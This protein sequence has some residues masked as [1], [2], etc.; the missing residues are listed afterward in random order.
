[1]ASAKVASI[2]KGVLSAYVVDADEL[3]DRSVSLGFTTT[4]VLK[5]AQLK[6]SLLVDFGLGMDLEDGSVETIDVKIEIGRSGI[7]ATVLIEGIAAT[8][9]ACDP[10]E[11]VL[12]QFESDEKRTKRAAAAAKRLRNALTK[13]DAKIAQRIQAWTPP[14]AKTDADVDAAETWT[15]WMTGGLTRRVALDVTIRGVSLKV[16]ERR[17]QAST[18]TVLLRE[19][20]A[21]LER[22]RSERIVLA[23]R[24]L[25]I[26]GPEAEGDAAAAHISGAASPR[27]LPYILRPLE[28]DAET[29]GISG[30]INAGSSAEHG[31]VVS[32]S[33]VAPGLN[34]ALTPVQMV[35][36]LNVVDE[37]GEFGKFAE[38]RR[39]HPKARALARAHAQTRD[40]IAAGNA[41]AATAAAAEVSGDVPPEEWWRY[42]FDAL[43]AEV[44]DAHKASAVVRWSTLHKLAKYQELF[45]KKYLALHVHGKAVT[46]YDEPLAEVEHMLLRVEPKTALVHIKRLRT[47]ALRRLEIDMRQKEA[48]KKADTKAN[49]GASWVWGASEEAKAELA[50]AIVRIGTEYDAERRALMMQPHAAESRDWWNTSKPEDLSMT[51]RLGSAAAGDSGGGNAR[52]AVSLS[53]EL[54]QDTQPSDTGEAAPPLLRLNVDDLDVCVE[55]RTDFMDVFASI[56]A[57]RLVEPNVASGATS[58]L[59]ACRAAPGVTQAGISVFYGGLPYYA[60][61]DDGV[62]GPGVPWSCTRCLRE[63]RNPVVIAELDADAASLLGDRNRSAVLAAGIAPIALA[64]SAA[65]LHTVRKVMKWVEVAFRRPHAAATAEKDSLEKPRLTSAE[66]ALVAAAYLNSQLQLSVRFEHIVLHV[67]VPNARA[68]ASRREAIVGATMSAQ[69][70][71]VKSIAHEGK[72]ETERE[73]MYTGLAY[74]FADIDLA[75]WNCS[76]PAS[77]FTAMIMEGIARNPFVR[78][79][80][81]RVTQERLVITVSQETADALA[82]QHGLASLPQSKLCIGAAE[83]TTMVPLSI[84]AVAQ[85]GSFSASVQAQITEVFAPIA[86][87]VDDVM[88]AAASAA[89]A[90]AV[91][92]SAVAGAAE[93]LCEQIARG[94]YA[95]LERLAESDPKNRLQSEMSVTLDRVELAVTERIHNLRSSFTERGIQGNVGETVETSVAGACSAIFTITNSG[96]GTYLFS[97][98]TAGSNYEEGD[99]VVVTGTSLNG[100]TPANDATLTVVGGTSAAS[101][102]AYNVE[103]SGTPSSPLPI[104]TLSLEQLNVCTMSYPLK[105]GLEVDFKLGLLASPANAG[106]GTDAAAAAEDGG[107][108]EVLRIYHP[109]AKGNAFSMSKETIQFGDKS[110]A[111]ARADSFLA[112]T[113]G[114]VKIIAD[115][116]PAE[117]STPPCL[118]RIQRYVKDALA[119]FSPPKAL[120]LSK[121]SPTIADVQSEMTLDVAANEFGDG[122]RSMSGMNVHVDYFE[123]KLS[124]STKLDHICGVLRNVDFDM[125]STRLVDLKSVRCASF[126]VTSTD[127]RGTT[128]DVITRQPSALQRGVLNVLECNFDTFSKARGTSAYVDPRCGRC[129]QR[130]VLTTSCLKLE[131]HAIFLKQIKTW[132]DTNSLTNSKDEEREDE[133]GDE[134]AAAL[135]PN[136]KADAPFAMFV[137]ITLVSTKFVVPLTALDDLSCE[138]TV[139]ELHLSNKRSDAIVA[140][141]VSK[142][143]SRPYPG[144]NLF[145]LIGNDVRLYF[146]RSDIFQN[147]IKHYSIVKLP[148]LVVKMRQKMYRGERVMAVRARTVSSSR[149]GA[150][151]TVDITMSGSRMM[152][153]QKLSSQFSEPDGAESKSTPTQSTK[154]K[155]SRP[156]PMPNIMDAKLSWERMRELPARK[157]AQGKSLSYGH[158]TYAIRLLRVNVALVEDDRAFTSSNSDEIT[159]G[160]A[161]ASDY[162]PQKWRAKHGSPQIL[163]GFGLDAALVQDSFGQ[164]RARAKLIRFFVDTRSGLSSAG[165]QWPVALIPP[166]SL[167]VVFKQQAQK[168]GGQLQRLTVSTFEGEEA[169]LRIRAGPRVIA[170]L[171]SV[172][173]NLTVAEPET[174]AA[175]DASS[176]AASRGEDRD[177]VVPQDVTSTEMVTA[178][179]VV[180]PLVEMTV[181]DDT[182]SGMEL[183][184]MRVSM[185]SLTASVYKASQL[186]S[187]S[188]TIQTVRLEANIRI[189]S[190]NTRLDVPAWED[191]L[192]RWPVKVVWKRRMMR[193][194]GAVDQDDYKLSSERALNL[195][196]TCEGLGCIQRTIAL[197]DAG[198]KDLAP[199]AS[200]QLPQ[201]VVLE[202][203]CGGPTVLVVK[204]GKQRDLHVAAN[205]LLD[206]HIP[207]VALDSKVKVGGAREPT[208]RFLQLELHSGSLIAPET[209]EIQIDMLSRMQ[210]I[211]GENIVCQFVYRGVPRI[212]IQ[213]LLTIKS[214]V[215]LGF[216]F[217]FAFGRLSH[218]G[219]F[220]A[221]F[222]GHGSQRIVLE[223][224]A[225]ACVPVEMQCTNGTDSWFFRARPR[226]RAALGERFPL[227]EWVS[228]RS[229]LT[230]N[231]QHSSA[232]ERRS[233]GRNSMMKSR[234]SASARGDDTARPVIQN[235]NWH[236]NPADRDLGL[237]SNC[238][239]YCVPNAMRRHPFSYACHFVAS[240]LDHPIA[241]GDDGLRPVELR[242]EPTARF[243]NLLPIRVELSLRRKIH[244][245]HRRVRG[246]PVLM[247]PG[248]IVTLYEPIDNIELTLVPTKKKWRKGAAAENMQMSAHAA[249]LQQLIQGSGFDD[250]HHW[251]RVHC[252]STAGYYR[253]KRHIVFDS[254]FWIVAREKRFELEVK[255]ICPE[256]TGK[257]A[258]GATLLS[259]SIVAA[260]PVKSDESSTW[261]TYAS[262]FSPHRQQD[263]EHKELRGKVKLRFKSSTTWSE[264]CEFNKDGMCCGNI[265]DGIQEKEQFVKISVPNKKGSR[266][267]S[268]QVTMAIRSH[269]APGRFKETTVIVLEPRT[270]IVN[271]SSHDVFYK[272]TNSEVFKL[273]RGG[274]EIYASDD[275]KKM[276]IA[277]FDEKG[278]WSQEFKPLDGA[279]HHT[280]V[281]LPISGPDRASSASFDRTRV[282]PDV[283]VRLNSAGFERIGA[284]KVAY[285]SLIWQMSSVDGSNYL[286]V[287]DLDESELMIKVVNESAFFTVH[288]TVDD[289][290]S[291]AVLMPISYTYLPAASIQTCKLKLLGRRRIPTN[292]PRSANDDDD[293][294]I[295][296]ERTTE[297]GSSFI[298]ADAVSADS[299]KSVHVEGKGE[300]LYHQS[301]GAGSQQLPMKQDTFVQKKLYFR[302]TQD[303]STHVVTVSD[304]DNRKYEKDERRSIAVKLDHL[305]EAIQRLTGENDALSN[306][307]RTLSE[308]DRKRSLCHT[309]HTEMD[310]SRRR[311]KLCV[312]VKRCAGLPKMDEPLGIFS[313]HLPSCVTPNDAKL[314]DPYA[315]ASFGP[316]LAGTVDDIPGHS[317]WR[318]AE[319][320]KLNEATRVESGTKPEFNEDLVLSLEDREVE[321][322]ALAS[323]PDCFT[324]RVFDQNDFVKAK[325]VGEAVIGKKYWST[326]LCDQSSID[327]AK[328]ISGGGSGDADDDVRMPESLWFPLKNP[329]ADVKL[330]EPCNETTK[331]ERGNIELSAVWTSDWVHTSRRIH[332]DEREKLLLDLYGAK[333]RAARWFNQMKKESE[334]SRSYAG[335]SADG[336]TLVVELGNLTGLTLPA[337]L[338]P[339]SSG[340][341]MGSV[342]AFAVC[343]LGKVPQNTLHADV[344]PSPTPT[345]TRGYTRKVKV[346][347]R[348]GGAKLGLTLVNS[349]KEQRATVA[350]I[351]A[352]EGAPADLYPG[353]TFVQLHKSAGKRGDGEDLPVTSLK[354]EKL[355]GKIQ[356]KEDGAEST[357]FKWTHATLQNPVSPAH[358]HTV[359]FEHRQLLFAHKSRL[360]QTLKMRVEIYAFQT[361]KLGPVM[362]VG[363]QLGVEGNVEVQ[364]LLHFFGNMDGL[365]QIHDQ[366]R[367][368]ANDRLVARGW[369][370][371]PSSESTWSGKYQLDVAYV[372]HEGGSLESAPANVPCLDVSMQWT[373][374]ERVASKNNTALHIVLPSL[375]AAVICPTPSPP[376]GPRGGVSRARE[377]WVHLLIRDLDVL[378]Q[379]DD[380]G[381]STLKAQVDWLEIDSAQPVDEMV[382]RQIDPWAV[383]IDPLLCPAP[384]PFA[385]ASDDDDSA[386][387]WQVAKNWL[388]FDV[389][390]FVNSNIVPELEHVEQFVRKE[391]GDTS[392]E[393]IRDRTHHTHGRAPLFLIKVQWVSYPSILACKSVDMQLN[394]T[395]VINLDNKGDDEGSKFRYSHAEWHK[396]FLIRQREVSEDSWMRQP[397]TSSDTS[398][399]RRTHTIDLVHLELQPDFPEP[400]ADAIPIRIHHLRISAIKVKIGGITTFVTDL[401]MIGDVLKSVPLLSKLVDIAEKLAGNWLKLQVPQLAWPQSVEK[402]NPGAMKD[403]VVERYKKNIDKL[404]TALALETVGGNSAL[405]TGLQHRSTRLSNALKL[406]FSNLVVEVVSILVDGGEEFAKP[407][408][409]IVKDVLNRFKCHGFAKKVEDI[410]QLM[411]HRHPDC[412]SY[413]RGVVPHRGA[414][415]ALSPREVYG[416]AVLQNIVQ[417]TTTESGRGGDMKT[418]W[419]RRGTYLYHWDADEAGRLH[420]FGT[421]A[422]M[423]VERRLDE[424]FGPRGGLFKK[425]RWPYD[426][427]SDDQMVMARDFLPTSSMSVL[428]SKAPP[429]GPFRRITTLQL[430]QRLIATQLNCEST[431]RYK[432]TLPAF[433]IAWHGNPKWRPPFLSTCLPSPQKYEG[434]LQ[435]NDDGTCHLELR[436]GK[437]DSETGWSREVGR[438]DE[439]L[440]FTDDAADRRTHLRGVP[441]RAQF[442][443][444]NGIEENSEMN[445]A[446][447]SDR[448]SLYVRTAAERKLIVD[449]IYRRIGWSTSGVLVLSFTDADRIGRTVLTWYST[450]KGEEVSALQA[451]LGSQSAL[452][453]QWRERWCRPISRL[454][455]QRCSNR[456][457]KEVAVIIQGPL[458][459]VGNHRHH[460]E[461]EENPEVLTFAN[462]EAAV[463]FESI[464]KLNACEHGGLKS[465]LVRIHAHGRAFN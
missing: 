326:E 119:A 383:Q 228:V 385:D 185:A 101:L 57:L 289:A 297:K 449:A 278:S 341:G 218:S 387:I 398:S 427:K 166:I 206:T 208:Q 153:L 147:T 448:F 179:A 78:L 156:A 88:F 308:I 268:A 298:V 137:N 451:A 230:L 63:E 369:L 51:I 157:D 194:T 372:D 280:Q 243:E 215:S 5:G 39:F 338:L 74:S 105:S 165:R 450:S 212:R 22:E 162:R 438:D 29:S 401:G 445:G 154:G 121:T 145:S 170:R 392:S 364:K 255:E 382:R 127:V 285:M 53:V 107:P 60:Q 294:G 267:G 452:R 182:I 239:H 213:S 233:L 355:I 37:L 229:L 56:G 417:S 318:H 457:T 221:A 410:A 377:E 332:S 62:N 7:T 73:K 305:Q 130:I 139:E 68:R 412:R 108:F 409:I 254:E 367:E 50:E 461:R 320:V 160:A 66:G 161:R 360:D 293:I 201:M 447:V 302:V 311:L 437:I 87:R 52:G 44:K 384:L 20:T 234:R 333:L 132:L 128:L 200:E 120:V 86:Q 112:L 146:I 26:I 442:V 296:H 225:D 335:G 95:A 396:S 54:C 441:F 446:L 106:V 321:G 378:V 365:T 67:G 238:F 64:V 235:S 8:L 286:V 99:T 124:L 158:K 92:A 110:Y 354:M 174:S 459:S 203:A 319:R 342:K 103:I 325:L 231:V 393:M 292:C 266:K 419:K 314:C 443:V 324:I 455:T 381:H 283:D 329:G 18:M 403:F 19:V 216:E 24:G 122:W 248:D 96:S 406:G 404:F 131:L 317:Y 368:H 168:A 171:Q 125:A 261:T 38:M 34:I 431:G 240:S 272:Q 327:K 126:V 48:E 45:V 16:R 295:K 150:D 337:D 172:V 313:Q 204:G 303:K 192:L 169:A 340:A 93:A 232:A 14:D 83:F 413:F 242:L 129:D 189:E 454:R 395:L 386:M 10:D 316:P 46:S 362:D 32:V 414:L 223:P 420:E 220:Q 436:D 3:F 187:D 180:L 281:E 117:G 397:R 91:F 346:P 371:V 291:S 4:L 177:T 388:K 270:F 82:R 263:D 274:S 164:M 136:A 47:Q 133:D 432:A 219:A 148:G 429:N 277:L 422:C 31:P 25:A 70:F 391:L 94:D 173:A 279:S 151:G 356:E 366:G 287:T 460:V 435:I 12:A 28:I 257:E 416:H 352:V 310:A 444:D 358:A 58:E 408:L 211:V 415:M 262:L 21:K 236:S 349:G 224:G 405:L 6:K 284:T 312:R 193:S 373:R 411:Q 155:V 430:E 27:P 331:S 399:N 394:R 330:S 389:E 76:T 222:E 227:S 301:V 376:G 43:S 402:P 42:A 273:K 315:V 256:G 202:N 309:E 253:A 49:E 453:L 114:R 433:R 344:T 55:R 343:Y 175:R 439:K 374:H 79:R 336:K 259:R 465:T 84:A 269:P 197:L 118:I 353:A 69:R 102:S 440:V 134:A 323:D 140:R 425:R 379:I 59:L 363:A 11:T 375:C 237:R 167:S 72:V 462:H 77:G 36:I 210:R 135:Q 282:L 271:N 89:A 464:L 214:E 144:L 359:N 275:S 463:K 380:D 426:P 65:T 35:R 264:T 252:I 97:V 75:L 111:H 90:A 142:E 81:I 207:I 195:N 2:L 61:C 247:S 30:W 424:I 199:A 217:I 17:T 85:I 1:M 209:M 265:D 183:A 246:F 9:V 421:N 186:P 423:L 196:V 152:W 138:L 191:V 163:V 198:D 109:S 13:I 304:V 345:G 407:T 149:G 348:Q 80:D 159:H 249:E 123:V 418:L 23:V 357:K 458:H 190:H 226:R 98:T 290:P 40:A 113:L 15:E 181:V 347:L 400:K 456:G 390:R 251:V 361:H 116:M 428:R 258:G 334:T 306:L 300:M 250:N 41:A 143:W 350:A 370:D 104:A 141:V 205:Q 71:E 241:S 339:Q 328:A 184:L 115:V 178:M 176:G 33:R 188:R 322:G 434:S 307:H 245:R 276:Q 244:S 100:A 351:E 260:E 288:C 299:E